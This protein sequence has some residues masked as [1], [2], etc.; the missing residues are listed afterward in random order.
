MPVDVTEEPVNVVLGF[1]EDVLP[2]SKI[3]LGSVQIEVL[4]NFLDL[5]FSPFKASS[6]SFVVFSVSNPSVL[7]LSEQLKPILCLALCVIP[8]DIW[9]LGCLL[10][11]LMHF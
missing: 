10:F 2:L 8:A 4:L 3:L 11:A 6:N 5:F 7:G 9:S 1:V